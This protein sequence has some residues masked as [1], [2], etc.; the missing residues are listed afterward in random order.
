VKIE[1]DPVKS[2][3]NAKERD[4]PFELAAEL[5][6]SAG[7]IIET[8]YAVVA[9]LHG[10]L[11]VV[12]YCIRGDKRRIMSF[13]RANKIEEKI[14]AKANAAPAAPGDAAPDEA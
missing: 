5:D 1:F 4:L 7:Q 12:A 2:A 8:R 11:H 6:W 13:R 14:Y 9:P 3:K 10:R